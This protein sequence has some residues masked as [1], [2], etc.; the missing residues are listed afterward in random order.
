MWLVF[1]VY[2]EHLSL[3]KRLKEYFKG[4]ADAPIG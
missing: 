2:F 4:L 3:E 1:W